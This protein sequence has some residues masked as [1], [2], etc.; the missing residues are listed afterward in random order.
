MNRSTVRV[1]AA[2]RR[3]PG[4][5]RGFTLV[6]SLMAVLIVS[7]VLVASL[8]T[9]GAIGQAR[10][11]QVERA[12]AFGLAERVMAE[13]LQSRFE[14]PSGA[15]ATL[16]PDVGENGRA[17]YDDVDDYDSWSSSPPQ[18]RDGTALPGLTGW[19]V[20]V[21]VRHVA[22]AD[23]NSTTAAASGLKR[24]QM[25]VTTPSGVRHELIALRSS[26]GAY[27]QVPA[28][29]VNYLTWG[30]IAVRV[31][32]RGRTVHGGAHPLNVTTSQ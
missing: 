15:T 27:E 30:G 1:R 29:T 8:G 10:Q 24:V 7:G 3:R 17:Q 14:E 2:S 11:K 32:E 12:Q 20:Q 28:A 21:W 4:G 5:A 16:G 9:F 31:G 6:E 22:P 26:S 23:P 13:V 18:A 25:R 19:S